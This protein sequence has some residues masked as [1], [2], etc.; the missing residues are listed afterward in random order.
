MSQRSLEISSSCGADVCQ[1]FRDF[2]AVNMRKPMTLEHRLT[3]KKNHVRLVNEMQ[4]EYML[5]YFIQEVS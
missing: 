2:G 3:L 5:P 1:F 4:L